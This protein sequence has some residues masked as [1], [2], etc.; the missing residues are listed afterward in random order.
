MDD[1]PLVVFRL[2]NLWGLL[3]WGK[4]QDLSPEIIRKFLKLLMSNCIVCR[5]Y[6]F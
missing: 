2:E 6:E 3:V 5:Q 1:V 4:A